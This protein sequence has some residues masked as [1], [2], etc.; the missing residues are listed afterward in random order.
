MGLSDRFAD[1][2]ADIEE[3]QNDPFFH[4]KD[5]EVEIAR[6]LVPMEAMRQYLDYSIFF[7]TVPKPLSELLH[8][9]R[10]LDV[11]GITAALDRSRVG[12]P[13]SDPDGLD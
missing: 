10:A 12:G 2:I 8:E 9:L 6:V 5:I 4:R 13:A 3:Y 7:D 1:A 11:S